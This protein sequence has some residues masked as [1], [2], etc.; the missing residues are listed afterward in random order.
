MAVVQQQ[1][2]LLATGVVVVEGD[3]G[4]GQTEDWRLL[5]AI[6]P[7]SCFW[8]SK[9]CDLLHAGCEGLKLLSLKLILPAK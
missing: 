8:N 3:C 9:P 4:R 1:A 6:C 2:G 5:C 7:W